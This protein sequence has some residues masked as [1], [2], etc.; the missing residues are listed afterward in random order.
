MNEEL[1]ICYS[2]ISGFLLIRLKFYGLVP[3]FQTLLSSFILIGLGTVIY[4]IYDVWLNKQISN[5][6]IQ[7][8]L[9][10]TFE[11]INN[12][13]SLHKKPN[14]DLKE[15]PFPDDSK[16]DE[17]NKKLIRDSL[18]IGLTP[19]VGILAVLYKIDKNFRNAAY[20]ALFSIFILYAVELY[21][22]WAITTDFKGEGLEELRHDI[23]QT[24]EDDSF[25]IVF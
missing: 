10:R 24:F 25:V 17:K 1:L 22:S 18:L 21:F 13:T 20:K 3:F 8:L 19:L 12:L 23:V 15:P 4:L 6:Q 7:N 9:D 14:P 16:A 2:L 5:D 11:D